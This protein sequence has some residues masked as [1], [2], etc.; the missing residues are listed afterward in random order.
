[1]MMMMMISVSAT[2]DAVSQEPLEI[3]EIIGQFER[4][5]VGDGTNVLYRRGNY[6]SFVERATFC[7]SVFGHR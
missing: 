4:V 7:F 1:M 6:C 2:R 3:S 5:Q